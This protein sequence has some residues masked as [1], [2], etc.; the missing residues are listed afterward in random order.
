[1]KYSI[2]WLNELA[3]T[4][5]APKEMAELFTRHSFEVEEVVETQNLGDLFVVGNVMEV[6]QHPNADRLK[7][8]RTDVGEDH[9]GVLTIVCGSPNV[10]VGQTVAVSLPGAVLPDGTKIKKSLIRGIESNGMICGEDE[11]GL[12]QCTHDIYVFDKRLEPGLLVRDVLPKQDAMID[13][14]ILSA[15]GHDALSHRGIARE[16]RAMTGA[17]ENRKDIIENRGYAKLQGDVTVTIEA[18]EKCSRYIGARLTNIKNGESPE[19]MQERLKI[20][21]MRP[22]SAVVDI[23]NYVM[24]ETGQ[25]LHAFDFAE[26]KSEM[27]NVKCQMSNVFVRSAREGEE[28]VLLDESTITL[29]QEDIVIANEK[30]ILALAG[31]MGGKDSGTSEETTEIFLESACFDAMNIRKTRVRHKLSTESSYRFE[32]DIDPNMAEMG[33][34][35]AVELLQELCGAEIVSV[36]DVYPEPSRPW[37]IELDTRYIAKL[38]GITIPEDKII[39]ILESLGMKVVNSE[40]GTVNREN[41]DLESPCHLSPVTRHLSIIVPTFRR[42]LHAQEDLIEEIG[43]LYG[44]DHIAPQAPSVSLASPALPEQRVFERRLKDALVL[45]GSCEVLSYSFYRRETAT[46]FG[47]PE[48]KHF[49]LQNPM[50]PDQQLFQSNLVPN[51]LEK[52]RENLRHFDTVALFEVG[53]AYEKGEGGAVLEKKYLVVF[54]SGEDAFFRLKGRIEAVCE[55]LHI[56]NI[57]FRVAQNLPA[58]FHT[59]RTADVV[60]RGKLIGRLGEISPFI[61]KEV[62]LKKR[63]AFFEAEVGE[64]CSVV[65]KNIRYTLLPKYPFVWRDMSLSVPKDVLVGDVTRA[66]QKAIGK[67]LREAEIFDVYDK[68]GERSIAYH[69]AFG[70]DDRTLTKEEVEE[71]FQKGLAG[72]GKVGVKLK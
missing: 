61:A 41:G 18:K 8:T 49:S 65:S 9:G 26:I 72:V 28:M 29:T 63:V 67:S 40:Q 53:K 34:S 17:I 60:A 47:L 7:V 30:G 38:L 22:V 21:G 66:L 37:T 68:D 33:A 14:S 25:P 54:E 62:K 39:S 69:L 15:R 42:D 45:A 23:T 59:T 70:D 13:L 2:G 11:L 71:M 27:S 20:C 16:I 44:Y 31:V 3:G 35:R 4:K 55:S 57:V 24:L 43:R 56:E 6:S 12:S 19:W 10:S 48:E 1:M 58:Y 64:L 50:N 36:I 32:R 52:V 5:L 51:T 46:I